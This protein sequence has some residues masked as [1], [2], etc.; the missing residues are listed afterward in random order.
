MIEVREVL[1]ECGV[2]SY[3]VIATT[4][5]M[6]VVAFGFA[7]EDEA[8][9]YAEERLRSMSDIEFEGKSFFLSG[10]M[11]GVR[12]NNAVNFARIHAELKERGVQDV[13]DPVWSW[14]NERVE[15][16]V[17]YYMQMSLSMLIVSKWDYVVMLE[18]W[19]DSDGAKLEHDVAKACGMNVIE[20]SELGL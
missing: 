18:G 7:S 9:E 15:K 1:D 16:S 20:E 19:E 13:Y 8:Y 2:P 4:G 10:P 12:L 6:P 11:N 17:E 14:F 5:S 3:L